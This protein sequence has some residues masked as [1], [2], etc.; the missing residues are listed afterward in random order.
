MIT[1]E[2]I[3]QKYETIHEHFNFKDFLGLS[4]LIFGLLVS[5]SNGQ[6]QAKAQMN[7]PSS[8]VETIKKVTPKNKRV[9]QK[10]NHTNKKK[11]SRKTAS[12]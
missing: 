3:K 11:K 4:A 8:K 12:N 10:N 1:R 7:E 6:S 2:E 9:T 5:N